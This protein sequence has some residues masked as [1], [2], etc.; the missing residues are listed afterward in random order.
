MVASH[1][2]VL[3]EITIDLIENKDRLCLLISPDSST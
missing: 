3:V 1:I 2:G